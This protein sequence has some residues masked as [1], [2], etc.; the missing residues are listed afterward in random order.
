MPR[1]DLTASLQ[2]VDNDHELL[3]EMLTVFLSIYA[4][5]LELMRTAL[6]EG[7]P[8]ALMKAAHRM[9]GTLSVFAISELTEMAADLERIGRERRLQGAEQ[10]LESLEQH[11]L[12]LAAIAQETIEAPLD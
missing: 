11:V 2:M 8:S 4:D 10:L 1:F 12:D 5:Q 7:D 9:K 3:R 6:A